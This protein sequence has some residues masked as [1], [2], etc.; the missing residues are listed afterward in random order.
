MLLAIMLLLKPLTSTSRAWMKGPPILRLKSQQSAATSEGEPDSVDVSQRPLSRGYG[1][2]N[3]WL[4]LQ[5]CSQS[6][7]L[8]LMFYL[9]ING[10]QIPHSTHSFTGG[11]GSHLDNMD[12]L[13]LVEGSVPAPS[14]H[15]DVTDDAADEIPPTQPREPFML[16][17]PARVPAK[18]D[19]ESNSS[20]PQAIY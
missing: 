1:I 9:V 8:M 17:K 2:S 5:D 4:N 11:S 7:F 14:P 19:D 15:M 20:P 13:P 18:P 10:F 16:A 3:M 12:T 6:G